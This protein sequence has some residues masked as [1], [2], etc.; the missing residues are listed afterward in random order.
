M[1][2]S[3][4]AV[5]WEITSWNAGIM[6]ASLNWCEGVQQSASSGWQTPSKSGTAKGPYLLTGGG[7]GVAYHIPYNSPDLS[8][9]TGL[10]PVR[11]W[12]QLD[13]ALKC[14][15]TCVFLYAHMPR[16][17]SESGTASP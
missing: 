14:K 13:G 15:F 7:G 3:A 12:S 1:E 16:L 2:L 6:G 8:S 4:Q 17:V 5:G 10:L 11:P 9:R